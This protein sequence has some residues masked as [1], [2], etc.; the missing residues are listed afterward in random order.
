MGDIRVT[1]DDWTFLLEQQ[2]G[3]RAPGQ[4]LPIM[5]ELLRRTRI[6]KEVAMDCIN[7]NL[8]WEALPP[9][10]WLGGLISFLLKKEDVFET[11]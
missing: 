8:T 10:S 4:V 3:H 11:G 5:I 2:Q 9:R 1:A 6:L 7:G